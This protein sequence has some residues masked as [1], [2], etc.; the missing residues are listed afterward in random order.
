MTKGEREADQMILK[1]SAKCVRDALKM[2][3]KSAKT[4][5]LRGYL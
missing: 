2:L 4:W 5:E 1:V 3:S